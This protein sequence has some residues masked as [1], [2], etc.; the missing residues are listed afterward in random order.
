MLRL[1]LQWIAGKGCTKCTAGRLSD[2]ATSYFL[3]GNVVTVK[4]REI[5]TIVIDKEF[6]A[7]QQ[8]Q[9]DNLADSLSN[10][11]QSGGAR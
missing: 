5:G 4:S 6:T 3:D 11:A 1:F 9:L 7:E 10:L 2:Y 8:K